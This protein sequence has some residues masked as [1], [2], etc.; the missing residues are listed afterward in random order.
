VNTRQD[1]QQ[2]GRGLLMG[3]ADIIPGVSGGTV[4][5]IL[6]IYERLVTA[7]SRFDRTYLEHIAKRR[8]AA[9]I[10]HI[11]LRFLLTLLIG[12]GIGAVALAGLM[13]HL[14]DH[15]RQQTFAVFFG[16]ILAS[17]VIVGRKAH[18][19]SLRSIPVAALGAVFAFFLVGLDVLE[20]PPESPSYLFLCGAISIC[21]MI[22]PGIS[23]SFILL[24]MGKYSLVI[25]ILK[26]F[27]RLRMTYD[28][29]VTIAVFASGALIGLLSFSKFLKW[30]LKTHH[31]L[32]M[33]VLC[34]FMLGSLRKIWPFQIDQSPDVK[35]FAAKN[36]EPYLPDLSA[37]DVQ[38]SLALMVAAFAFVFVLEHYS[39][40]LTAKDEPNR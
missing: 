13:H 25:G 22:L 14:L 16:L 18:A 3:A 34:G 21:A 40:R 32:T 27:A 31:D 8:T 26:E 10:A 30:L 4:A 29:F 35:K 20:S 12:I 23:G 7:I 11:D 24:I 38:L 1:L 9:A 19:W 28:A 39:A 33:I 15:Q 37:G 2:V 6:G 17:S 36:F 5:L